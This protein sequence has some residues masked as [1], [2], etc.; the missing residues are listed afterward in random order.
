MK[1]PL[2]VCLQGKK[3]SKKGWRLDLEKQINNGKMKPREGTEGLQG[4]T[5][6]WFQ[7]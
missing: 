3:P 1:Q 4:H 2:E 7:N 6:V 5:A